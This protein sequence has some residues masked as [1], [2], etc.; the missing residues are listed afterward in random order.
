MCFSAGFLFTLVIQ[1]II[2]GALV[3]CII[4]VLPWLLRVLGVAGEVVLQVL[5]IIAAALV[6]IWLVYLIW[7][8]W[9]CLPHG[10]G[11]R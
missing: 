3:A 1:L 8:L 5:R 7:D 10:P 4:V 6:L 11:L 2:I 9:V